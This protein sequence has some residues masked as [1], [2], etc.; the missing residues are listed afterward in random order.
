LKFT[1]SAN[2]CS[3]RNKA[4]ALGLGLI[5][6]LLFAT[7]ITF[8]Q[9]KANVSY[10]HYNT[11]DGLPSTQVQGIFEDS[12]GFIWAITDRG[13]ARFNGYSFQN[14][15]THNGLVNNNVLLI[16]EDNNGRIWFMCANGDY[17][18]L[19]ND[20][21]ISYKG[22]SKIKSLL[23][24][25]LPGPFYFDD[26]DTMWV[27]TFSGIQLFKCFG[28][29]VSEFIPNTTGL[30]QQP[31]YY[32]RKVHDKLVALQVGE[33]TATN[34]IHTTDNINYLLEVA[35]EC[36][37]ACSVKVS[38]EQWALAGPG[39][40]VVFN[41]SGNLLAHF[42]TSPYIFSTLEHD[43]KGQLWMTNSNGAYLIKDY[44]TGPDV[45]KVYFEGHFISAMLQ[46]KNGNYWFGDRDNGLF[47]VPSLDID[48]FKEERTTKQNKIVSIQTKGEQIFY[49]DASGRV[50]EHLGDQAMAINQQQVPSAVTLDFAPTS[51][52]NFIVGNKPY[53]ISRN[54]SSFK[55]ITTT[56]TIRRSTSLRNGECAF[57]LADGLAF[58]DQNEVW[59]EVDRKIYKERSNVVY[60]DLQH[61]L[62]IGSN[63][64][65]YK[66]Q[67]DSVVAI[68]EVNTNKPR[69]VDLAEWKDQL[70]IGTRNNGLLFYSPQ[71]VVT[72]NEESG[73][74]SNTVDCICVEDDAHLWIGTASGLQCLTIESLNP[75][76][77]SS[78]IF[79]SDKGL[80]S[81]EVN[82]IALYKGHLYVATNDGLAVLREPS[83]YSQNPMAQI[84]LEGISIGN[85]KIP[86]ADNILLKYDENNIQF[87]FLSLNYRTGNHTNYRYRLLGLH[88]QWQMTTNT[89]AD[90]WALEPGEYKFE[91]G[92]MNEDGIWSES[93]IVS[94]EIKPHFTSTWWFRILLVGFLLSIAAAIVL[95]IYRSKKRQLLNKLKMAE[96]KQ[97]ALNANMNPHFIFNS[98]NS[99]QHFINTSRSIEAN[100]YLT[101]FSKLIRMNLETNQHNEVSLEDELDR[102]ELYLKLEKLRF[103]D[104]LQ[105]EIQ[106]KDG[107]NAYDL[108]IPPMLLQP[109]VENAILHG[110]LPGEGQGNVTIG[111]TKSGNSYLVSIQDDGIG[112]H[113]SLKKKTTDHQSLAM[114]MNK[115]RMA[116]LG[117]QT[118]GEYSILVTDLSD[119]LA[120]A[121]GTSV[122]IKIP[123]S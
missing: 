55:E 13:A 33:V 20:T 69:V 96:L 83:S 117:E 103:G 48:I 93:K 98:L 6:A 14:F 12:K 3:E 58:L 11:T 5:C 54:S 19:M 85:K 74:L 40:Y 59:R 28:D 57:A 36:K 9:T 2:I 111:V 15:T 105:Y 21:I 1:Y 25:K 107:L 60:E 122:S 38:P 81:N 76:R 31:T 73:L 68:K 7:Q 56:S 32:L 63:S 42:N 65:L 84:Y 87:Q 106:I 27:T 10:K 45:S 97:Q 49:S 41:E 88:D 119:V 82:D 39:G 99:I 47:F 123:L 112:I 91:V 67:Q 92:S 118:G 86:L 23:K 79:N 62:W 50:F 94:I 80:P 30:A 29:S 100:D 75:L 18:Y 70:V 37:L 72:L 17:C 53:L 44:L 34:T 16:N 102:L 64:G 61:V 95:F 121:H 4:L 71:G 114:K 46:D 89:S 66:W 78:F 52:G 90:Y 104:K 101:D 120:N 26:R 108:V 22:N 110:I 113:K 51:K 116:L 24:D 109:Y 77:F 8:G 35:G 115:E 43:R